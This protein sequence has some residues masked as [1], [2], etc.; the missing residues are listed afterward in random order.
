M[1]G[2][3][4]GKQNGPNCDSSPSGVSLFLVVDFLNVLSDRFSA[5]ALPKSNL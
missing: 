5:F 3:S 1:R 2:E 4:K